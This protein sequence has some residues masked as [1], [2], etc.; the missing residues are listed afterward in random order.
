[1]TVVPL[2][3][4]GGMDDKSLPPAG[5]ADPYRSARDIAEEAYRQA[6]VDS[7]RMND[8]LR[9]ASVSEQP[10]ELP[11]LRCAFR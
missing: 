1:M 8:M 9:A 3:H 4:N 5:R 6:R 10:P 7:R 2:G 11:V